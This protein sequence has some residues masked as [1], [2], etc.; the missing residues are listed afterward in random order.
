L[1]HLFPTLLTQSAFNRRLQHLW[2]AFLLIQNAVAAHLTTAGDYDVMD[3][4]P[5]SVA[6][7][8]RSLHPGWLAD[9]ARISK[10]GND[11]YFYG[12]R[13]MMVVNQDGVAT[14]WA[15][16]AGNVQERWVAELLLSTRAEVPGVRGPLD[17]ETH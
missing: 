8:A 2:G 15:L 3:R 5:I 11:R 9:I 12:V 17:I 16:A 14:G 1:G 10:G 7:G 4:F 13:M 6:H